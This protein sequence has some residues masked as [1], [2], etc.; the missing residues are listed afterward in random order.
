MA[1]AI[2]AIQAWP[3]GLQF[4][5]QF[6]AFSLSIRFKQF[7]LV[8]VLAQPVRDHLKR[9]KAFLAVASSHKYD[10]DRLHHCRTEHLTQLR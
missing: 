9:C 7:D 10:L 5:V 8:P 4:S 3:D 2:S 1:R 6:R